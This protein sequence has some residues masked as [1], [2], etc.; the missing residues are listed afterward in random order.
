M[1]NFNGAIVDCGYVCRL[2]QSNHYQAVYQKY[3]REIILHADRTRCRPYRLV[4]YI[5]VCVCYS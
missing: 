2:L 5:G 3:K 1:Y 4:T